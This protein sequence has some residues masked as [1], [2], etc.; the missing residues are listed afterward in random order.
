MHHL[1]SLLAAEKSKK[2]E[3]DRMIRDVVDPTIAHKQ[4]SAAAVNGLKNG[5]DESREEGPC[6]DLLREVHALITTL[7]EEKRAVRQLES[8]ISH[9][10]D[11]LKL[12]TGLEQIDM[13]NF[14]AIA[15]PALRICRKRPWSSYTRGIVCTAVKM[16]K[17]MAVRLSFQKQLRKVLRINKRKTLATHQHVRLETHQ[18]VLMEVKRKIEKS[19]TR[20]RELGCEF[21]L[22]VK[23]AQLLL[24]RLESEV[25][26]LPTHLAGCFGGAV[27]LSGQWRGKS[28]NGDTGDA[29]EWEDLTII[30]TPD[31]NTASCAT[32][33]IHGNGYVRSPPPPPLSPP[34]SPSSS[35]I[36]I[37]IA[38]IITTTIII[39]IIIQPDAVFSER[40]STNSASPVTLTSPVALL[41]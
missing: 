15:K 5:L 12:E 10:V 28:I 32:G 35:S 16:R 40:S 18:H 11:R 7:A 2:E 36:T 39:T 31:D 19:I 26:A 24:D 8:C 14:D 34:S 4:S 3:W 6:H 13:D 23:D 20:A 25:N 38:I 1:N 27:E 17:R 33:V 29:T 30:F 21:L 37:T 22:M 9:C 41:I